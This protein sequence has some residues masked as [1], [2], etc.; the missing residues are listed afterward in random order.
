MDEASEERRDFFAA[1]DAPVRRAREPLRRSEGR[2]FDTIVF[3]VLLDIRPF[4]SE[5]DIHMLLIPID[6]FALSPLF[7]L[8]SFFLPFFL[9]FFLSVTPR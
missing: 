1:T 3:V 4:L 2:V 6:L 8:L 5:S 9:S 7:L